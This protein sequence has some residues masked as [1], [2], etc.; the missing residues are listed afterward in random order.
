MVDSNKTNEMFNRI[1]K[2]L[3][4]QLICYCSLFGQENVLDQYIQIGLQNN[5]QLQQEGYGIT[6]QQLKVAE[7][8]ANRLPVVTFEP[9]YLL[10]AGGRR[11]EFP[12]G[13]LFNPAYGALNE[14]T[15][16]NTFPT[17]LEN[18]DEHHC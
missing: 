7:A 11:L 12:V 9:N 5:L 4:I 14:L 2:S 16:Q 10:A 8:K 18:V 6:Q 3:Y 13:D 17:D 1:K 15:Q